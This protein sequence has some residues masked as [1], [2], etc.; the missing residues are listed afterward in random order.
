[1][2]LTDCFGSGLCQGLDHSLL[3]L[4]V[5]IIFFR[6][7]YWSSCNA[8]KSYALSYVMQLC[9]CHSLMASL[10]RCG[11]V[12]RRKRQMETW[13]KSFLMDK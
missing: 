6:R 11:S 1:L 9:W 2:S 8:V 7:P 3:L 12:K 10:S 4:Y 5:V 13:F